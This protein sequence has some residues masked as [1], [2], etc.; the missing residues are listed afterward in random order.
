MARPNPVPPYSRV[1]DPSAC[2]NDSKMLPSLSGGMPMP[3]SATEKHSPTSFSPSVSRSTRN[4]TSPRC[5]NL[6]ALPIRF[7]T[8]CRSLPG[9]PTSSSGT[10][11]A[12]RHTSSRPFSCART[13]KLLTAASTADRN[14][15]SVR[16][17][18]KRPASSFEKSN[19]SLMMSSRASPDVRTVSR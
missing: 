3:V 16:S 9:S 12:M 15:K 7:T 18:E 6:I 14:P 1:V 4:S 13:A 5:V 8:T 10:S 19:T 11:W 17:I 2:V